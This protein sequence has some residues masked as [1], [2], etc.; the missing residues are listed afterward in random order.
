MCY[1]VEPIFF[2]CG[3]QPYDRA[4]ERDL[5][6]SEAGA[7]LSGL[8]AHIMSQ[9]FCRASGGHA[10]SLTAVVIVGAL[11]AGGQPGQSAL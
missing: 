6:V 11:R 1:A 2:D 9:R 3:L 8:H 5:C 10:L 7:Q 4:V